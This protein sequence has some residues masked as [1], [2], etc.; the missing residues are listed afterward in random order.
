MRWALAGVVALLVVSGVVLFVL[1]SADDGE[2]AVPLPD[3]GAVWSEIAAEVS[4]DPERRYSDEELGL[5]ELVD[6][7]AF[8]SPYYVRFRT[9]EDL[10]EH[11]SQHSEYVALQARGHERER[12]RFESE[13]EDAIRRAYHDLPADLGSGGPLERAFVEWMDRCAV[14]AGFPNIVFDLPVE[15]SGYQADFG[16]PYEDFLDLRQSCAQQAVN[17][18]TLDPDVRDEMLARMRRHYL[19]AAHEFIH[20]SDIV[21]IPVEHDE[22]VV[23]PLEESYIERCLEL[24]VDERESCAEYYRVELTEEQKSA[25]VP[26]R[27]PVDETRPYPLV[28]QPCGFSDAPGLVVVDHEG[29]LCDMFENLE[30]IINHPETSESQTHVSN[31]FLGGRRLLI[32]PDHWLIDEQHK[33][34]YPHP[35][36]AEL[37]EAF[38]EAHPE[39]AGVYGMGLLSSN[40]PDKN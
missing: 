38:I 6:R 8:S 36:E 24:E 37:R 21:E 11:G 2:P 20:L 33:C 25:P 7:I 34:R 40:Y 31:P 13:V 10:L 32:C 22:G 3:A 15:P 5:Y 23:H 14:D 1:W 26:E 35:E 27:E 16:L 39:Q 9:E 4:A 18:P 12:L 29:R 28:G 30:F 17:Y 19:Q